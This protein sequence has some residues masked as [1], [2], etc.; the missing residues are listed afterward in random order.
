MKFFSTLRSRRFFKRLFNLTFSGFLYLLAEEA[1]ADGKISIMVAG[2]EKQIYLPVKLAEQLGYFAETGL[3]IEFL[4]DRNGI[5]AETELLSGSVQGVVGF[6]D[7]TINLQ[8]RGKLVKSVIQLTQTPGEALLVSE[9]ASKDI[10]SISQLKGKSFGVTG[11]GSSTNIIIRY[12]A[13]KSGIKSNTINIVPVGAGDNFVAAL[14][15][16]RVQAGLTTDP[17]I[18][19]LTSSGRATILLD[20]RGIKETRAAFGGLYPA[21]CLY[22]PSAWMAT[23]RSEVQKIVTALSKSLAYIQ[24]HTALEISEQMP[25]SF[26]ANDKENYILAL[27]NSKEMFTVDGRMPEGGPETVLNVIKDFDK[28]VQGKSINLQNTFTNEFISPLR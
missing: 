10:T 22:M 20:L 9:K 7:H 28:N 25:T 24:T 27:K 15:Q 3:D 8:A 11:L 6:Y 17:T 18:S 14:G 4:T 16:G 1:H 12:L 21:A 13:Q 19:R 2:I 26:Y 23:H 5:N